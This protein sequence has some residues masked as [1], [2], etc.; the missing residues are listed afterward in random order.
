MYIKDL[1]FHVQQQHAEKDAHADW[2][3]GRVGPSVGQHVGC[4]LAFVP[5]QFFSVCP[6]LK[7]V[8]NCCTGAARPFSASGG[9]GIRGLGERVTRR[10]CGIGFSCA[11]VDVHTDLHAGRGHPVP[12]TCLCIVAS[13]RREVFANC[14]AGAARPLGALVGGGFC[15]LRSMA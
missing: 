7:H 15:R 3:A 10:C 14:C 6:A 4:R 12:G 5:P 2:H 8:A 9:G 1:F 13:L 11:E